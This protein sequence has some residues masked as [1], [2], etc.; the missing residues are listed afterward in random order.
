MEK[1]A[2][3]QAPRI[4]HVTCLPPKRS[5]DDWGVEADGGRAECGAAE[6]WREPGVPKHTVSSWKA[7]YGGMT[8]GEAQRLK[9]LEDENGRLKK[10]VADLSLDKDMVKAVIEKNGWSS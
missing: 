2:Y 9:Q 7:T 8:V 6:V 10:L 1:N 4:T 3:L 5:G